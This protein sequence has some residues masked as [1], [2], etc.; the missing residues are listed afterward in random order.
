MKNFRSI[1]VAL[2][3]LATLSACSKKNDPSPE[4]PGDAKIN[5]IITSSTNQ[6][7]GTQTISYDAQD[8]NTEWK[9]DGL[10]I[11]RE[12][13]DPNNIRVGKFLYQFIFDNGG[14]QLKQPRRR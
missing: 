2:S 9:Y 11:Y 4:E 10:R 13:A 1:A 7:P 8:R 12:F 3:L 14:G 5:Q 6:T